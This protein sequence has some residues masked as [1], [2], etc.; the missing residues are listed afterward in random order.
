MI[1]VFFGV[2][3]TRRPDGCLAILFWNYCH[4]RQDA[5]DSR[6]LE[7]AS[8]QEIYRL[9]EDSQVM[10]FQVEIQGASQVTRFQVTRF[11][12]QQGSVYDAWVSM[13]APEHILPDDL[14]VLRKKMELDISVERLISTDGVLEWH[15]SVEP[16]GVTLV[17]VASK[18]SHFTP[19]R[20]IGDEIHRDSSL[21]SE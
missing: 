21:R 9:F 12:R 2:V 3:V 14:A 19:A 13:G 1:A 16:F 4:Y 10:D 6:I 7:K 11:D 17:E 15:T 20:E 8:P 5:N 18:E